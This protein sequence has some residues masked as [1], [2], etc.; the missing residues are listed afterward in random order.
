MSLWRQSYF[1][2]HKFD[3]RCKIW[4]RLTPTMSRRHPTPTSATPS[5]RGSRRSS[6][7]VDATKRRRRPTWVRR[8]TGR[9]RRRRRID[10]RRWKCR[11]LVSRKRR[12][13]VHQSLQGWFKNSSSF[14]IQNVVSLDFAPLLQSKVSGSWALAHYL[15]TCAVYLDNCILGN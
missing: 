7:K 3:Q 8:W 14:K 1:R 4:R 6:R 5:R 13:R 9:R 15:E 2:T 11:R 12:R 10:E